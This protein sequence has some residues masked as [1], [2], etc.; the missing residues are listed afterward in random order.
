MTQ[1]ASV[2]MREQYRPTTPRRRRT[3]IPLFFIGVVGVTG[4]G[5]FGLGGYNLRLAR[6]ARNEA[7]AIV[8]LASVRAAQAEARKRARAAS[9]GEGAGA[10]LTLDELGAPVHATIDPDVARGA[11]GGFGY[12][13]TL[14]IGRR[15]ATGEQAWYALAVPTRYP[16]TAKRTFY[17][18][19]TLAVRVADTGGV[20]PTRAAAEGFPLLGGLLDSPMLTGRAR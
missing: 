12:A 9:V 17:V 18:D 16:W 3:R 11:V 15:T 13:I 20:V 19:E 1:S 14:G 6:I 7:R 4:L 8:A 10:Y 2:P 5:G